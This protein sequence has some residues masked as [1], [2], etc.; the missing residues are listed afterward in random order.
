MKKIIFLIFL[1]S[2][3][4]CYADQKSSYFEIQ[5]SKIKYISVNHAQ[6]SISFKI[7]GVYYFY[8]LPA[9]TTSNKIT[10]T[11]LLSEAIREAS[12]VQIKHSKYGLHRIITN[13]L[14]FYGERVI[15]ESLRKI[16]S[17]KQNFSE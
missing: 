11:Y 12:T 17:K 5:V 9:K 1:L 3:F 13:L 15:P 2:T 4:K 6:G 8:Y 7:N 10:E 14:L 16:P